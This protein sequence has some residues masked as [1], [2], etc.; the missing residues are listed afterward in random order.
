[1][2]WRNQQTYPPNHTFSCEDLQYITA[3][4]IVRWVK[5]QVYGDP[6]ADDGTKRP[7]FYGHKFVLSWKRDISDFMPNA[8]LQW[9]EKRQT[10]NPT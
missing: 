6:Y 8:H 5:F 3:N 2:S 10:G 7:I 1:M 9:N 4:E